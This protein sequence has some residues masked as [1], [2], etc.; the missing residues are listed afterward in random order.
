MRVA[1]RRSPEAG[2]RGRRRAGSRPRSGR[3]LRTRQGAVEVLLGAESEAGE[4]ERGGPALGSLQERIELGGGELQAHLGVDAAL[5]PCV[6]ARSLRSSSTRRRFA[7]RRPRER[8]GSARA[9]SASCEPGGR[10][11][12]RPATTETAFSEARR[13]TSSRTRTNAADSPPGQRRGAAGPPLRCWTAGP[14]APRPRPA[15]SDRSRKAPR[16]IEVRS[17][18]GSSCRSPSDTQATG[19]FS[20]SAHSESRVVL[21][22]PAGAAT[23]SRAPSGTDAIRASR[24]GR[25]T[26]P[27]AGRGG[28]SRR[29]ACVLD[30]VSWRADMGRQPLPP[31]GSPQQCCRNRPRS[32]PGSARDGPGSIT[33][34]TLPGG[35][36]RPREAPVNHPHRTMPASGTAPTVLPRSP[37]RRDRSRK[38]MHT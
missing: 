5:S 13:W 10:Q 1:K 31:S 15:R 12:S 22:Y 32:I 19:R 33:R 20:P 25:C 27:A 11:S 21:P 38:E 35:A 29:R 14:P 3:R 28:T 6:I 17:R 30:E 23:S 4:V 18:A 9:A 24:R 8:E 36:P 37:I 34:K 2:R 16:A 7:R 26:S